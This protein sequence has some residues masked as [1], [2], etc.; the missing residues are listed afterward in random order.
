MGQQQRSNNNNNNNNGIMN[1]ARALRV[2]ATGS[3]GRKRG[4]IH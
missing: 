4:P 3:G 1:L 2:P